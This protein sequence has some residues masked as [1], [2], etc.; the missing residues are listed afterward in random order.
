[1]AEGA[2]IKQD[3]HKRNHCS[4]GHHSGESSRN[5]NTININWW[6]ERV[7][8][9]SHF[10]RGDFNNYISCNGVL[11]SRGRH[12]NTQTHTPRSVW[13]SWPQQETTGL[14]WGCIALHCSALWCR[15]FLL[16]NK[17]CPGR[18]HSPG[19]SSWCPWAT[20]CA[21]GS[22]EGCSAPL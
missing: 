7:E 10:T 21:S 11:R 6:R 2:V 20:L 12:T 13:M 19:A 15:L 5:V 3:K 4:G 18:R 16:Q 22:L 8:W 14:S 17:S 1:M 9:L